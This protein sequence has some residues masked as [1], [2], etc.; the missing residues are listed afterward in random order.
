MPWD[1]AR[2]LSRLVAVRRPRN[3]LLHL[4]DNF[5]L[6]A[7]P[8]TCP[9][10]IRVI[11]ANPWLLLLLMFRYLARSVFSAPLQATTSSSMA[12]TERS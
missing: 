9:V 12:C 8:R 3:R 11:R 1:Y 5:V 6:S 4:L 10:L 2:R 7:N